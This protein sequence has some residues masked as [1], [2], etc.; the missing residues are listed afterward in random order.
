MTDGVVDRIYQRTKQ[1]D[2]TLTDAEIL[3]CM[4]AGASRSA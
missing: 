2:H 4:D 1:R 3:E